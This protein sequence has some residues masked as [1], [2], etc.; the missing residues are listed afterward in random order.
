MLKLFSKVF[1]GANKQE[2]AFRDKSD[3]RG[4]GISLL[5]VLGSNHDDSVFFAGLDNFPDGS[6]GLMV[7]VCRW[8]VEEDNF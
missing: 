1:R 8:L 5:H 2:F 4:Q 7:H 3:S 6:F